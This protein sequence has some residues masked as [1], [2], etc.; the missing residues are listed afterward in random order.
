MFKLNIPSLRILSERSWVKQDFLEEVEKDVE[1]KNQFIFDHST[2]QPDEGKFVR[3]ARDESELQKL[4]IWLDKEISRAD[5]HMPSYMVGWLTWKNLNNATSKH[6]RGEPFYF[7]KSDLKKFFESTP[8]D[9]IL[10]FFCWAL[11]CSKIV[12]KAI[13]NSIIM[14]LWPVWTKGDYF[15]ARWFNPS[16]RIAMFVNIYFFK[17]LAEYIFKKYKKNKPKISFY[18]DDI[19][20]SILASSE[21]VA[22]ELK[23]DVENFISASNLKSKHLKINL[24]KTYITNIIEEND[25]VEYLW[26]KIYQ[27]RIEIWA[28]SEAKVRK[29]RKKFLSTTNKEEKKNLGSQLSWMKRFKKL[30]KW[31]YNK[32]KK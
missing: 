3:A 4:H 29:I 11:N 14:P 17:G 26:T 27:N 21:N 2:S 8:Q 5:I 31:G 23:Q 32:N 7:I 10:S 28:K 12:A 24:K 18:I 9:Q 1:Y 15:L 22:E 20:I 16:P 13:T 25:F 30:I 19:W 6:K